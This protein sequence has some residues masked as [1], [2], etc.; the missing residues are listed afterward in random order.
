MTP[1]EVTSSVLKDS[2][3][4]P[5]LHD[6]FLS[7]LE[8]EMW[9]DTV[10]KLPKDSKWS[11]IVITEQLKKYRRTLWNWTGQEKGQQNSA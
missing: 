11:G 4:G 1:G 3:L 6:K 9:G 10:Q 8:D 5:A 2:V 7:G